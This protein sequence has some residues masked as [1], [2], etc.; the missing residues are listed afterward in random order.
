M[1]EL[2]LVLPAEGGI[3][4]LLPKLHHCSNILYIEGYILGVYL[5]K[6]LRTTR[7][8]SISLN[9]QEIFFLFSPNERDRF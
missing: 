8:K 2:P 7:G 5:D 4:L 9:F 3:S 6:S 1:I